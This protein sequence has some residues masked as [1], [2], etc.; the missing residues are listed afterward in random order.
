MG[1]ITE[2]RDKVQ[3]IDSDL[4]ASNP[5]LNEI[6]P[7]LRQELIQTIIGVTAISKVHSGPLP[8][9]ETL[10]GYNQ[11]IPN[12]AERLMQQV[13][14]Q[15]QHRRDIENRVIKWNSIESLIGQL[16]GMIIAG[17]VL[18]ASYRLAMNGH[19]AVASVLGG[20]TIVGLTSIFV[21][22][23]KKQKENF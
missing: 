12:G 19:E 22:G 14:K 11:I 23:K 7:T 20:T 1:E 2:Q 15:S 5:S 21:Y 8:D 6:D 13:E 9:V 16:C 18:F 17:S 4:V 3:K 10:N